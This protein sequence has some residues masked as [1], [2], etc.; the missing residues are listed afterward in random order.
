[1]VSD[2]ATELLVLDQLTIL[3]VSLYEVQAPS[4]LSESVE[5]AEVC[6]LEAVKVWVAPALL[7]SVTVEGAQST[8][9]R[10]GGSWPSIVWAWAVLGILPDNHKDNGVKSLV[11]RYTSTQCWLCPPLLESWL[12]YQW[13]CRCWGP[14]CWWCRRWGC[15]PRTLTCQGKKWSHIPAWS[16]SWRCSRR[17]AAEQIISTSW[18][19]TELTWYWEEELG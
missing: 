3:F 1:M 8:G 11:V 5:V 17:R 2:T 7:N 15:K 12:G 19:L 6:P 14:P 18:I 13:G 4:Y 16:M 10:V 9:H